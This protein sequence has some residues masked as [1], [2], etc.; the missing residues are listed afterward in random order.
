MNIINIVN[1]ILDLEAYLKDDCWYNDGDGACCRS[2]KS[3]KR[4][5][6]VDTLHKAPAHRELGNQEYRVLNGVSLSPQDHTAQTYY[7]NDIMRWISDDR[8][9]GVRLS[10]LTRRGLHDDVVI[11]VETSDIG[12]ISA[13]DAIIDRNV[14]E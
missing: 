9:Y 14:E 12:L 4:F 11:Y 6:F 2:L 13:L 10:I 5:V 8:E 7:G 3:I 1:F